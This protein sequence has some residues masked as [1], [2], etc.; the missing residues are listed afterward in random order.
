MEEELDLRVRGGMATR[1]I[2]EETSEVYRCVLESYGSVINQLSPDDARLKASELLRAVGIAEGACGLVKMLFF[3]KMS[4]GFG[5]VDTEAVAQ[6]AVQAIGVMM[7]EVAPLPE[8]IHIGYGFRFA[9]RQVVS[10][11][12]LKFESELCDLTPDG[13]RQHAAYL[14]AAAESVQTDEFLQDFIGGKLGME[15]GEVQAILQEFAGFRERQY[16]QNLIEKN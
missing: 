13:A 9:K 12:Q 1:M 5:R 4:K 2:D 7:Q 11:I 16:F 6:D 14:F 15:L 10:V 8:D 3:D